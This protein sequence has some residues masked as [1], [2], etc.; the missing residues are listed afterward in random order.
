MRQ[1]MA[2]AVAE[3]IAAIAVRAYPLTHQEEQRILLAA[4]VV[5]LARTGVELDFRGD[6]IDA[7]APEMPTRFAKQLTQI[8]RGGLGM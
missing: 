4:D 6:V 8:M 2:E 1:E 3:L 7:H 5:T